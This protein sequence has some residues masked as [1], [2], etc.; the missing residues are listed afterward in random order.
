M[1]PARDWSEELTAYIDGE[2]DA[3]TAQALEAQLAVDPALKALEQQ[4]RKTVAMMALMPALEPSAALRRAVLN[5]VAEP[6]WRERVVSLLSVNRLVPAGM[7]AAAGVAA[8]L[9]VR[10]HD[11]SAPGGVENEEQLFVAQNMDVVEDLDLVG[12]DGADDFEVVARLHELNE[13]KTP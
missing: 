10:G 2:L 11:S 6:S 4:L 7:V 3:E 5:K 1:N 13:G 8:F 12:L 9:V